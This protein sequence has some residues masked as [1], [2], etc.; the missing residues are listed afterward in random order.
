MCSPAFLLADDFKPWA[1]IGWLEP[2]SKKIEWSTKF[3][4]T[5]TRRQADRQEGCD[6]KIVG[7]YTVQDSLKGDLNPKATLVTLQL[8]NTLD[9]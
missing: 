8:L 7:N 4:S 9:L 1:P 5:S 3:Y 2:S 6:S